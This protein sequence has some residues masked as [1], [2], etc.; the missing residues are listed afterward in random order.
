MSPD[1]NYRKQQLD[2]FFA[3]AVNSSLPEETQSDLARH[4]TVLVCGFIERSVELV[5]M[6]KIKNRAQPRVLNFVRRH[7]QRGTNYDCETITQLL[8]RFDLDWAR[9]FRDFLGSRDD[10]VQS[11]SSAY[12]LRNSIAHGATANPGVRRV[13]QLYG[14]AKTVIDGLFAATS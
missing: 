7:F 9:R 14:D 11:I 8:E 4:G 10:L 3:R 13:T 6:D 12:S 5:I 1:I 2:K